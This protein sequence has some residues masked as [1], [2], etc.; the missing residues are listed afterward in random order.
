M[1]TLLNKDKKTGRMTFSMKKTN[2]AFA[3]ALRRTMIDTVPTMAVETVEFVKN[4]SALYDEVLA[5]RIGLIP[6]KTDL[7]GY[8]FWKEGDPEDD[9]RSTLKLTLKAKGPCMV[10]AEELQSKDPKVKPAIAKIP[11][12]QLLKG[13][14]LELIATARLGRGKTHVKHSPALVWYTYKPTVKVNNTADV[15]KYKD[16]YPPQVFK[17]GKIDAKAIEELGLIE[18]CDGVNEDIVKIERDDTEIIFNIEP[19]G[20]LTPAQILSAAAD[21]LTAKLEEFTAKVK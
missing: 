7:K 3:N 12:V 1:I 17:N 11:I 10:Y 4:S 15:E 14:E 19:W 8:N 20:Q 21:E 13:Q 6:I 18:A 5:N 9:P 16:K 2:P